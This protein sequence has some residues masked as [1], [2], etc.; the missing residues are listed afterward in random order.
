MVRIQYRNRITFSEWKTQ[1]I[2][3]ETTCE[4]R[5]FGGPTC[6]SIFDSDKSVAIQNDDSEWS[7]AKW[8]RLA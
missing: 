2:C 7:D 4:K 6:R 1:I 8:I 5:I 3:I